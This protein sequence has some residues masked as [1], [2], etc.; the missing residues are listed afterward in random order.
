MILIFLWLFVVLLLSI[1]PSGGLQT[2]LPL[3]KI[4]HFII[5]GITSIILFRVLKLRMSV[6]K[7]TVLSIGIASLYGLA[8][9]LLQSQLPWRECSFLDEV[10][11]ISGAIFFGFIYI[12][13]LKN[14]HRIKAKS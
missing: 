12:L 9:E 3:D 6:I 8:M 1:M 14:Y 7:A 10:A 11:N 2:E 13:I 5:Y 4:I